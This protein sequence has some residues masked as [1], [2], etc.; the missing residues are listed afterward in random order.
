VIPDIGGEFRHRY[1]A[2]IPPGDIDD[3]I[4][5]K[6]SDNRIIHS[7]FVRDIGLS[8]IETSRQHADVLPK[9]RDIAVR[10]VRHRHAGSFG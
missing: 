7:V 9:R 8:E 10:T 1:A 4:Q 6:G 3:H 5:R 2:R